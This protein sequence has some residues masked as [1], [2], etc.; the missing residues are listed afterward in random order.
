MEGEIKGLY[1]ITERVTHRIFM[2][3]RFTRGTWRS[4]VRGSCST[5]TFSFNSASNNPFQ[6][7][8][9]KSMQQFA[10]QV[11]E[12]SEDLLLSLESKLRI[13]ISSIIREHR[14]SRTALF[15]DGLEE[16]GLRSSSSFSHETDDHD[17]DKA[18]HTLQ[19]RVLFLKSV[20]SLILFLESS[21]VPAPCEVSQCLCVQ[22]ANTGSNSPLTGDIH[23]EVESQNCLLDRMGNNM[24]TSRGI[25]SGTM[26]RFKMGPCIPEARLKQNYEYL[27]FEIFD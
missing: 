11:C 7:M 13:K 4:L 20:V 10:V 27:T 2:M 19:D 9:L 1:G 16:G 21:Y 6:I 3:L 8:L 14:N 15:D 5:F 22:I 26:D 25:M 17:N 23:E 24:D 12:A 18:V